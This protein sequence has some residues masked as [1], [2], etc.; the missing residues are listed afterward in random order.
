[1]NRSLCFKDLRIDTQSFPC[2]SER[3]CLT[4]Q[5]SKTQQRMNAKSFMN[6]Y[7]KARSQNHINTPTMIRPS[8]NAKNSSEFEFVE[9]KREVNS[10]TIRP[11]S[12]QENFFNKPTIR[13][14]KQPVNRF[15]TER[16]SKFKLNQKTN[17]EL[18]EINHQENFSAHEILDR[19]YGIVNQN[20][21]QEQTQD[22]DQ[23][24]LEEENRNG[25][26]HENDNDNI[27]NVIH[28]TENAIIPA[29]NNSRQRLFSTLD[30]LSRKIFRNYAIS[31]IAYCLLIGYHTHLYSYR[32]VF[33]LLWVLQSYLIYH[34]FTR[35]E[36]SQRRINLIFGVL[37][38]FAFEVFGFLRLE[39][40][41]VPLS[42]SLIP[43][44]FSVFLSSY[45]NI[46][47]SNGN[48]QFL[49][50]LLKL[51]VWLQILFVCLKVDHFLD[52]TWQKVFCV[53]WIL[54]AAASLYCLGL[55]GM[56]IFVLCFD[57]S[58]SSRDPQV[59]GLGWISFTFSGYVVAFFLLALGFTKELENGNDKHLILSSMLI[60]IG[61]IVILTIFT[62]FQRTKIRIFINQ[63][64]G[65]EAS[66]TEPRPLRIKLQKDSYNLPSH[67]VMF[68]SSYFLTLNQIFKLKDKQKLQKRI[69]LIKNASSEKSSHFLLP[70][71]SEE[72]S[73][74]LKNVRKPK[75]LII[76]SKNHHHQH[77]ECF[78]ASQPPKLIDSPCPSNQKLCF[79]ADDLE[80]AKQMDYADFISTPCLKNKEND[81]D[82]TCIICCENAADAV[83]M[84]CGHGGVCY[85]CALE[86][87]QKSDK[88]FMCRKKIEKVLHIATNKLP[89]LNLIKVLS[90]TK[91]VQEPQSANSITSQNN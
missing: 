85:K 14:S 41:Q 59:I 82:K 43:I 83:I 25:N 18:S 19:D 39:N 34:T 9:T 36:D 21:N 10:A 35:S 81:D 15:V 23:E 7:L 20:Q 49:G 45:L 70:S 4:P 84:G 48:P 1:M 51:L 26:Q 91:I 30:D 60:G 58:T 27:E 42:V 3:N 67:I 76:P 80:Y 5:Y 64:M 29:Q 63:I 55:I 56:F 2:L 13:L 28:T 54:L 72:I 16:P 68:S 53:V 62:I 73:D 89:K 17:D 78:S 66:P 32:L 22:Q 47:R 33:S 57:R 71:K 12:T 50:I 87:C 44:S 65:N 61:H 38:L 79:T 40:V 52:W 90:A 74:S 31:L 6:L 86:S 46:Y 24:S 88:C 11:S 69:R 75:P 37:A 77:I 8:L